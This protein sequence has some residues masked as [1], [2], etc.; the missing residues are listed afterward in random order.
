MLQI[1]T[2]APFLPTTVNQLGLSGI[3]TVAKTRE[4]TKLMLFS[5]LTSNIFIFTA[6][7]PPSK[8]ASKNPNSKNGAPF[9]S[10]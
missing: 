6:M 5:K 2:T 9:L 7:T 10:I 1:K 4:S 8:I 3:K